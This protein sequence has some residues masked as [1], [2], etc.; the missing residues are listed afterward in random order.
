M[1]RLLDKAVRIA[2]VEALK[3]GLTA[4]D[5]MRT[6]HRVAEFIMEAAE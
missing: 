3:A 6:L 1:V 2:A 5:V 4:H